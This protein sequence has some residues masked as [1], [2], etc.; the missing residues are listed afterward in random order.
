VLGYSE[1]SLGEGSAARA[2]SYVEVRIGD[3]TLYG[4][5]MDVDIV[6]ASIKAIVSALL[7]SEVPIQSTGGRSDTEPKNSVGEKASSL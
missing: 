3:R 5:G 1:H 7:R 6:S 4:V 2:M